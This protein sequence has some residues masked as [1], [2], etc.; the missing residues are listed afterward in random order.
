MY[1]GSIERSGVWTTA[2][3]RN[4]EDG[5]TAAACGRV[6][7][8]GSAGFQERAVLSYL[9]YSD[10]LDTRGQTCGLAMILGSQALLRN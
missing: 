1:L 2:E 9:K 7:R 5:M 3:T 4:S 6:L 8:L 10:I